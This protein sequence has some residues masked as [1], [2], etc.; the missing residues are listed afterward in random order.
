MNQ[1]ND[2]AQ[3]SDGLKHRE[4]SARGLRLSEPTAPAPR[5]LAIADAPRAPHEMIT[6]HITRAVGALGL[7][8]S[9]SALQVQAQV[10]HARAPRPPLPAP[11]TAEVLFWLALIT[12]GFVMGAINGLV[13]LMLR[14][15]RYQ[16]AG[17]RWNFGFWGAMLWAPITFFLL[18]G[19]TTWAAWTSGISAGALSFALVACLT[20][21]M[22]GVWWIARWA[23]R[24]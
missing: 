5:G 10:T 9:L 3:V 7:I 8:L 17:T 15:W 23:A 21:N 20:L 14:R 12:L 22:G 11:A 6:R 16:E 2:S 18:R 1:I 24:E 4:S 13:L 19:L